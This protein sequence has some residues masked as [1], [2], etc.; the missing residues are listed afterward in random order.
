MASINFSGW[1]RWLLAAAFLALLSQS[2]VGAPK[3]FPQGVYDSAGGI[4]LPGD[5]I[6]ARSPR[7]SGQDGILVRAGWNLCGDDMDCLLDTIELNLDSA[8][9]LGLKVA[10]AIGDGDHAPAATKSRCVL[11]DFLFRGEPASMCLPWDAAYLADKQV[12]IAALGERFDDHPALAHIYFTAACSSNGYEGHCRIDEVAYQAAG[13]TPALFNAAYSDILM[14]YLA[15]F[16]RTPVTIELHAIFERVDMWETLWQIGQ[17]SGRVGLA[18]WWCA[19]RHSVRGFDTLP[20]WPLIQEAAA[21]TYTVC[22]TVGN[23]SLQPYRFTDLQLTLPL[24]YGSESDWNALDVEKAFVESA[25]W[26]SG[27]AV[28]AGQSTLPLPFAAIEVWTE[29]LRNPSFQERLR[30][31]LDA[32][33]LFLDGFE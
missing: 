8:A 6:V 28:H 27:V 26:I 11:F 18:A 29:D 16:A 20:V 12:L 19:E 17:G 1:C 3:P 23:F 31:L 25:D 9:Q 2:A 32:D 13:Y 22:Q 14:S 4:R 21:A 10:L 5:D 7:I 15:A 30:G 24:D 33:Q